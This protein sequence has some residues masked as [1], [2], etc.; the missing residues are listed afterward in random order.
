[1]SDKTFLRY[2]LRHEKFKESVIYRN[3]LNIAQ[4]LAQ[5]GGILQVVYTVFMIIAV[6]ISTELFNLK[7]LNDVFSI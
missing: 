6:L 7:I 2:T 4:V 5:V 1:M 3:Y